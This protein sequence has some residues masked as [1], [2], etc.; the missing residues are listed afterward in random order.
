MKGYGLLVTS[1]RLQTTAR[2]R[3]PAHMT[4]TKHLRNTVRPHLFGAKCAGMSGVSPLKQ[5]LRLRKSRMSKTVYSPQD[6][7]YNTFRHAK[8]ALVS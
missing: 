7:I 3:S 5:L 1:L 6:I 4:G 2:L 8:L